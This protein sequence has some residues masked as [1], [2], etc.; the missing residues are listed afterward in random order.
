MRYLQIDTGPWPDQPLAWWCRILQKVIPAANPD[1]EKYY[2]LTRFWW[3]ELD[4]NG[5]PKRE[6][7]FDSNR[8]PIV[9]GPI[10]NNYGFLVD[11]SDDW[12]DSK[13]DSAVAAKE[14]QTTWETLSPTFKH[15]EK[16]DSQQ[17][18]PPDAQ[19]PAPR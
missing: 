12:S 11:S 14:F 6:I 7:G 2:P 16:E 9:L 18:G 10:G 17:V 3:L 8:N 4:A 5:K 1:L 19:K 13:E 15:L